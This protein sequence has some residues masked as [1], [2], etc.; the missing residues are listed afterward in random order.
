MLVEDRQGT[1]FRSK[2]MFEPSILIYSSARGLGRFRERGNKRIV[3]SRMD[4]H[5][6]YALERL[7]L[8]KGRRPR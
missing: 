8:Q 1:W 5:M 3:L 7:F 2:L 4:L 6:Y